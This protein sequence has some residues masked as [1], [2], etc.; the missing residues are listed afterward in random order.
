MQPAARAQIPDRQ[1]D[2]E[3][4]RQTEECEWPEGKYARPAR[5][6]GG[7]QV[8]GGEQHPALVALRVAPLGDRQPYEW[9]EQDHVED[10]DREELQRWNGDPEETRIASAIPVKKRRSADARPGDTITA[11]IDSSLSGTAASEAVPLHLFSPDSL[12][13][14][15]RTLVGV[16]DLAAGGK[17][18]A[19]LLFDFGEGALEIFDAQRLP[20]DH[21]MKRNSHDP[22]LLRAV[23]VKRL[24]LIDHGPQILVPRI[25]FSN[26][27]RDVVDLHAIRNGEELPFLDLHWIGLI[28]VVPIATIGHAFLSEDVEGVVRLDEAGAEPPA[29][30]ASGRLLDRLEHVL[31]DLLLSLRTQAGKV[32]AIGG[33]VTHEFPPAFF[34]FLHGLGKGVA[35]RRIQ[36]DCRLDAC[37]IQH[38]G[39]APQA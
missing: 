24:E 27:E 21:G 18:D 5:D 16:D 31:D 17:P 15:I 22:R 33:P 39:D 11:A 34:H 12:R 37:R 2:Y 28:V 6:S 14:G 32:F 30:F 20:D 19:L 7:D 38:V 23:G 25:A 9:R 35:D 4:V 1:R 3:R 29:R 36:G 10:R 26:E 13:R 8:N